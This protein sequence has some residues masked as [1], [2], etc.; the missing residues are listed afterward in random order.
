MKC[1]H[2]R[3]VG[4]IPIVSGEVGSGPYGLCNTVPE[5]IKGRPGVIVYGHGVFTTGHTDFNR[6][7]KNLINIENN[8]REEYF[9][10]V[11]KFHGSWQR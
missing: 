10:R 1:P 5:A 7:F 9:N 2:E 4:G 8:C 3:F 6:P 11:R